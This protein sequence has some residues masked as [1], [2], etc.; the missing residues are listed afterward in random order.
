MD[1]PSFLKLEKWH[2]RARKTQRGKARFV[3]N[4]S[5]LYVLQS[6]S[7]GHWEKYL[8]S[9]FFSSTDAQNISVLQSM[10]FKTE[11][12]CT[13]DD[14]LLIRGLISDSSPNRPL[15]DFYYQFHFS[16]RWYSWHWVFFFFIVFFLIVIS[17]RIWRNIFN[18]RWYA[19]YKEIIPSSFPAFSYSPSY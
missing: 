9:V 12:C 13:K 17:Y 8:F 4:T 7:W 19:V 16:D 10:L 18:L 6:G 1:F 15:W 3:P 5:Q 14:S 2:S 11:E